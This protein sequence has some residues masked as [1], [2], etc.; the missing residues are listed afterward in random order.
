VSLADALLW[1]AA[2]VN[3]VLVYQRSPLTQPLRDAASRVPQWWLRALLRGQV[4]LSLWAAL[5]SSLLPAPLQWA[6]VGSLL[7]LL[8]AQR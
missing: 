7:G 4:W 3:L 2:S 1:L 5:L 8:L 6:L